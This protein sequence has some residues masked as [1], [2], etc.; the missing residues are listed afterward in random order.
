M[1]KYHKALDNSNIV[2][3]MCFTIEPFVRLLGL[4]VLE[5]RVEVRHR[6][7]P[8]APR[9]ARNEGWRSEGCYHIGDSP[10]YLRD[11]VAHEAGMPVSG[12]WIGNGG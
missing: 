5:S 6:D 2:M 4:D 11:E 1:G 12:K 7:D 8:S 9:L 3:R 10:V